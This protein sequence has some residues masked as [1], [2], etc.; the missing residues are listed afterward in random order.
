MP[1]TFRNSKIVYYGPHSCEN[2]GVLIAKMGHEWGGNAFTY[3]EGPIYPNTEW[4]PHVCDPANVE[5]MSLPKPPEQAPNPPS[6][7]SADAVRHMVN[8]FLGWKL[9][10]NFNP[11]GGISFKRTI[12]ENR[13]EWPQKN[14]PTGT[15]LFDA[16]QAEQM[17]RYMIE[18]TAIES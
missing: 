14:E 2:C 9:P 4:H 7:T 3:P 12:N 18:G 8:R 13:P 17:V 6:P 11:D 1:V 15:N 5:A 16:A 10:D